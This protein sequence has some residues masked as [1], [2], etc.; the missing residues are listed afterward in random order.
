MD[1]GLSAF[2]L[3]SRSPDRSAS[4]QTA[5]LDCIPSLDH[6]E[7]CKNVGIEGVSI[8]GGREKVLDYSPIAEP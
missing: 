4:H 1:G 2:S 3:E 8:V 5:N 6:D 7:S